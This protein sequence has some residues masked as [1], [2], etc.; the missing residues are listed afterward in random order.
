MS[1]R[2]AK[3]CMFVTNRVTNDPRVRREAS[4][5]A[6]AGHEVVVLGVLEREDDLEVEDLDGVT[7]RRLRRPSVLGHLAPPRL[8]PRALV[9]A[10]RDRGLQRLSAVQPRLYGVLRDVYVGLRYGG[11]LPPDVVALARA[12]AAEAAAGL[13]VA[14]APPP[15]ASS[16]PPRPPTP[17][18]RLEQDLEAITSSAALNV[19][20][21][22]AAAAE[23]ADVYHAHDLDTLLA[24]VLA[25]RRTG[26]RLVY[27][28]HELYPL[29]HAEGV[30]TSVWRGYHEALER[31]LIGAADALVTV[32]ESLAR[33]NAR[34]YGV[35]AALP[36]LNVPVLQPA[37][38]P[39][40][41][42]GAERV[43]LYHGG[44]SP[45]R[46]LETLLEAARHLRGARLVMRG[47]GAFE[48]ELRRLAARAGVADRV[49][50]APPVPMTELVRS[51]QE[52]DIGVIPY[53]PVCVN[54]YYSLPNKLFEYL[55]AGLAVVASDV[56]ELRRAVLGHEVGAV[57][58][59]RDA[60]GLA[61]A[62]D[63]LV[64]DDRRLEATRRAAFDAARAR[65]NWEV[66][67]QKLL[68]LYARLA[69]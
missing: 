17:R 49:T 36:L 47:V 35:L 59:P 6:R 51:A 53:L 50:F 18:E 23:R 60:R 26:A 28:F 20:L 5:L 1:R 65:F 63:G 21:A 69:G 16:A 43:V 7:V 32:N 54:N 3:V 39:T 44:Y 40:L 24:G 2:R 64:A 27:D 4:A 67:Q 30:K 15:A 42:P 68:D 56:P 45:H 33:H 46:G 38:R 58:D 8:S 25:K 55:M 31:R 62:I 37:P 48:A 9:D 41:R 66:E 10:A 52:A 61:A 12:R 19:R 14:A 11:E 22:R 29:Q 13:A 34:A 57:Y